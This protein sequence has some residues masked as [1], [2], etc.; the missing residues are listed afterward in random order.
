MYLIKFEGFL[1]KEWLSPFKYEHRI[2]WYVVCVLY[3]SLTYMTTN[4][5][6]MYTPTPLPLTVIDHWMPFWPPAGWV[7]A[8]IYFM[9][10]VLPL[11]IRSRRILNVTIITFF[12]VATIE[13]L[14]FFSFPT[15]YPREMYP[16][17][18]TFKDFPLNWIRNI[19]QP[20]NCFPSQHVSL[21]FLTAFVLEKISTRKGIVAILWAFAIAIS[22]LLTKQHYVWDL[23][24]GYAITRFTFIV[25]WRSV[26]EVTD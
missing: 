4:H 8:S 23:I 17:T 11:F 20:L 22:T 16:L 18:D 26:P 5:F 25:V 13:G 7:Y 19:D 24:F 1:K 10:M 9:P 6:P 14:I 15:I 3:F 2:F 21:A 12:L